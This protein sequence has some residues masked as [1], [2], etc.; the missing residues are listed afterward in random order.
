MK[1]IIH[2]I[3][4]DANFLLIPVQFQVNIYEEFDRI[5]PY[6]FELIV[7]EPVLQELKQKQERNPNQQKLKQQISLAIQLLE[8]Q[9]FFL[10]KM[11]VSP[12]IHVDNLLLDLIIQEQILHPKDKIFLATNDGE[13]RK[14][15]EKK[16]IRTIYLRKKKW[17]EVQ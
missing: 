16:K 13:L 4:L 6:P 10:R 15:A 3:F 14:Q 17:L 9:P 11:N 8:H 7:I 12:Q 5:V 2:K 1:K